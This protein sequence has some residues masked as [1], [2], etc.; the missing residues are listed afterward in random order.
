MSNQVTLHTLGCGS[1]KPTVR[2]Q[3][4]SSVL[5]V[6][7]NL[8]MIDCGEGAQLALQK[9][10]LGMSRLG[11][12]FLTHLHGDHVFG[13]P[14][15]V[16]SMGLGMMGGELTIHT[17][18]EGKK[19]LTEIFGYFS[20]DMP[21]E[22]KFNVI[23]PADGLVYENKSFKVRSVR[24]RHRVNCV[25]YVFEEKEGP[26]HINRPMCDFHGVPVWR[27]NAIKAGEDFVKE[28]GTVIA[29]EILTLPP[30]KPWSYAHISDTIYMPELA[31]KLRGTELMFHETTYCDRDAHLA[32]ERGHSTARQAAM[33]ARDA[34][35]G[36]LL[37]GHYSSRYKDDSQFLK[38]ASEIFPDTLLNKEG[39]VTTIR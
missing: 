8:F 28:D 16:G 13:L 22:V 24:L 1:A 7:G 32:K 9:Q 17:F 15:L 36:R 26:R 3:P 34:E 11:H 37:T 12:I 31:D 38:E 4:S 39:L 27:M 14:G 6:R 5:D 29:N 25:G 35:I 18:E 30:S 19:V 20:R 10:R 23:E 2:H 21:F 33:L